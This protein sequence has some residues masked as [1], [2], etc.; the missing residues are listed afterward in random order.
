MSTLTPHGACLL[1]KPELIWLNAV[2]D[3]MLA[4]R[5]L[6]HRLRPR[7]LRVA[8]PPR[9][10][11]HVHQRIL[12]FAVFAAVGGLSRLLAIVTLWVPVYGIEAAVKGVLAPISARS[13]ARC[14]WCC[15]GSW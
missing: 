4:C 11:A 10:A 9:Y 12:G 2:S 13:A 15:R 3:A 14:C 5:L 8:A 6:C 7:A 1:W